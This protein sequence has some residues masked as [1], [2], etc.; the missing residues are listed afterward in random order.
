[1]HAML[2]DQ[3]VIQ[4]K[5][6][7]TLRLRDAL[8]SDTMILADINVKHA[9][10]LV[11][12]DIIQWTHDLQDRG[13]VDA[14]IVSGSGTGVGVDIEELKLIHK[15]AEVPVLIGSGFTPGLAHSYIP[16]SQGAIVG[17]YF[18]ESGKVTNPID[19]KRVEEVIK[20]M[21]R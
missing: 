14:L 13:K 10:P 20:S 11:S 16:F 21:D 18:K 3:G 9:Q 17:S 8:K 7:E 15:H 4:G 5:S 12:P 2:T 6:Y 19:S 1:M